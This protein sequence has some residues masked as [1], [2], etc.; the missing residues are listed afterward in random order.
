M[1]FGNQRGIPE[2]ARRMIER[3]QAAH[4]DYERA[5]AGEFGVDYFNRNLAN[6]PI[7]DEDYIIS[8]IDTHR[9]ELAADA[10]SASEEAITN[11]ASPSA[12]P[13]WC[14]RSG[15][16]EIDWTWDETAA[17]PTPYSTPPM[18][19]AIGRVITRMHPQLMFSVRTKE[20]G[21]EPDWTAT[22]QVNNPPGNI[23]DWEYI[24][25]ATMKPMVE[26]LEEFAET[27]R[28]Q[29]A[30]GKLANDHAEWLEAEVGDWDCGG[31][32][33]LP[34]GSKRWQYD[35]KNS[36]KNPHLLVLCRFEV[37]ELDPP[38]DW[39]TARLIPTVRMKV[40][41]GHQ[42]WTFRLKKS[43][44]AMCLK[45]HSY[46]KE[47]KLAAAASSWKPIRHR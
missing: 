37:D 13:N 28:F 15:P 6:Y 16:G 31:M 30:H 7:I 36:A 25:K 1:K 10:A 4:D 41:F 46:F 3:M 8:E 42:A 33:R 9:H 32:M 12:S 47:D 18:N 39:A 17:T 24:T 27:T 40:V 22:I 2:G 19:A 34:T 21:C 26:F 44:A 35:S 14:P 20:S 23:K 38:T 45:W 43:N 11:W 29:S 5:A